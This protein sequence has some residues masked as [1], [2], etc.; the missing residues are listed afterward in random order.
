[1]FK[2]ADVVLMTKIDLA[3]AAGFD[4]AAALENL[5]LIAPQ[6]A[7]FELSARGGQGLEGWYAYL[8]GQVGHASCVTSD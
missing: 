6:A 2:T 5:R 8:R 3:G 1:V 4:R 7:V